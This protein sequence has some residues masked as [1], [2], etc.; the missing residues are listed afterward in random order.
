M[1][2][3]EVKILENENHALRQALKEIQEKMNTQ[4]ISKPKSCRYCKFYVQHYAKGIFP[5]S[6]T[7]Y[8]EINSGHCTRG[9]PVKNGGKRTPK[10]DDTCRYF[11]L[12]TYDW[13]G[14]L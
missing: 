4:E 2:S 13:Q 12:G 1:L 7:E 3:N 5:A 11:E 8:V 14:G 6:G 9:V 10:P